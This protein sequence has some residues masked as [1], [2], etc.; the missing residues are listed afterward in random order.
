MNIKCFDTVSM[1][2]DE[3]KERF[4]PF[5]KINEERYEIL[6]EYCDATDI[7]IKETDAES[8]EAEVDEI[9][10]TVS[11]TIECRELE[12]SHENDIFTQLAERAVSVEFYN[13]G[14][15]LTGIK[16]TFPSIWEKAM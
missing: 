10:M 1:V 8:L 4:A 12:V 16:L 3:A 2:V 13:S 14:S 6:K 7:L 15:D 5:H 9:E 11:V